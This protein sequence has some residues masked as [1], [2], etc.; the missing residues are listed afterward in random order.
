MSD[1]TT[2][3]ELTR[4][5]ATRR[6]R[7]ADAVNTLHAEL[8]RVK[9]PAIPVIRDAVAQ[10]AEAHAKL[11][12]AIEA[13]PALFEKP[14]TITVAGVR[15]G[16]MKQRGKVVLDDE[17]RTI[18]RIRALL[19]EDQAELLIRVRESVDKNAIS[20]LTLDDLRRLGIRVEDDTDVP[21]IKPV[22][23]EVDKLVNALL[24]EAE[25]AE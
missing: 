13:V 17:L 11:K 15:V 9:N 21:L 2:I 5:Y 18:E 8:E 14:R 7:V 24:A 23:T 20:D 10:A 12:A 22:D 16:Y 4:E 3:E 1:I 25:Q 19:P 6:A